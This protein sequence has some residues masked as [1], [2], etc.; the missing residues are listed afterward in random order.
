MQVT[1]PLAFFWLGY[2]VFMLL[3]LRWVIQFN[4][5][6]TRDIEAERCVRAREEEWQNLKTR[7]SLKDIKRDGTR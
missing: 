5:D 1:S 3:C 2:G 6:Y 7:L 4:K